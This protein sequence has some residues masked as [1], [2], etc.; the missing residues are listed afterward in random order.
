M[1]RGWTAGAGELRG[2]GG[3][4]DWAGGLLLPRRRRHRRNGQHVAA[5]AAGAALRRV[6]TAAILLLP[7]VHGCAVAI[8]AEGRPGDV[9]RGVDH[10]PEC[11]RGGRHD[12]CG[13][14][15][16]RGGLAP[17]VPAVGRSDDAGRRRRA[18]RAPRPPS[19]WR[20]SSPALGLLLRAGLGHGEAPRCR[21]R[22]AAAPLTRRPRPF[23]GCSAWALPTFASSWRGTHC[24]SGSPFT[25]PR[26]RATRRPP[27]RTPPPCSTWA[28]WRARCSAA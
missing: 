7:H 3:A 23:R 16:V 28:A 8:S 17:R 9:A 6:G 13:V 4:A 10:L 26:R 22:P 20:W 2:S 25:S 14:R 19:A 21:P 1:L 27:P 5:A 11:G 24:C 15:G 18:R 12:I